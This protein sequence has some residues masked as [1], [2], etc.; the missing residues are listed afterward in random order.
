[1]IPVVFIN[2][3]KIPYVDLIIDGKKKYETRHFNTLG[4]LVDRR[5][6]I[7][8]TH[9]GKT[10]KIR[11]SAVLK[12]AKQIKFLGVWALMR[13][14]TC[15]PENSEHDWNFKRPGKWVY[16]LEDVREVIGLDWIEGKRHGIV[17][18]E[19]EPLPY[20]TVWDGDHFIDGQKHEDLE[21]AINDAKDTLIQWMSEQMWGWKFDDKTNSPAP[22]EAQIEDWDYMIYNCGCYVVPFDEE[23]GEY[24]D[25]DDAVWPR[26]DEDTD[27]IGWMLWEDCVKKYGYAKKEDA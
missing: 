12:N 25:L 17:W 27:K 18:M 13:D 10:P 14:E 9:K 15:V 11:C 20:E 8:E 26:T 22:T 2:C 6:L 1:M 3:D 21:C 16:E 23:I 7:A 4:G 5:V 19:Y 24:A